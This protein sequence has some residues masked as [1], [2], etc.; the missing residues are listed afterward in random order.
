MLK[1]S[2]TL[3]NVFK[4]VFSLLLLIEIILLVS[5]LII[6]SDNTNQVSKDMRDN[7]QKVMMTYRDLFMQY[8]QNKY[9]FMIEDLV[10]IQ[11]A[12]D[13]V[14]IL[15]HNGTNNDAITKTYTDSYIESNCAIHGSSANGANDGIDWYNTNEE[16]ITRRMKGTWY[17]GNEITSLTTIK[18]EDKHK[19]IELCMLN[20][21]ITK[22]MTKNLKWKQYFTVTNIYFTFTF[23]NSFFYKFPTYNNPY[24]F[25][26]WVDSA[27]SS[28]CNFPNTKNVYEPKCRP[29]YQQTY[30]STS[31]IIIDKPY[32]FA[33]NNLF[34]SDVCIKSKESTTANNINVPVLLTCL[35]FNY[36]DINLFREQVNNGLQ[37]SKLLIV[38]SDGDEPSIMFNSYLNQNEYKSYGNELGFNSHA[39]N[40]FFE[41]YVQDIFDDY[42]DQTTA[43]KDIDEVTQQAEIKA[44]YSEIQSYYNTWILPKIITM[45][46]N[47]QDNSTYL[48]INQ[49]NYLTC[50]P[51]EQYY[52]NLTDSYIFK[53][54]EGGENTIT[55]STDINQ[56][57]YLLPIPESYEYIND[58]KITGS[59]KNKFYLIFIQK[60]A[61]VRLII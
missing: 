50:C 10:L 45:I 20:H 33:S 49:T 36:N 37:D 4:R 14:R 34:G 16:S 18:D 7:T 31:N 35:G 32:K 59:K 56:F 2:T 23:S 43:K 27:S 19:L 54:N 3:K 30:N 39:E 42:L 47:Y 22:I 41:G 26:N 9:I 51:P 1:I 11:K 5:V 15:K 6:Y 38:Y 52:F 57:F 13:A 8:L 58:Y 40:N 21:L 12:Y 28:S 55:L 48:N 29:F 25:P 60:Q 46:K 24:M 53:Y 44:R 17:M 61:K